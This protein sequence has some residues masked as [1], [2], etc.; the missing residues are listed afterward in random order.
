ME[1]NFHSIGYKIN[2]N[3]NSLNDFLQKRKQLQNKSVLLFNEESIVDLEK[4][5][6]VH[7][8]QKTA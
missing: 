4:W 3:N 2:Q 5:T 8:P 7:L 6:V 1:T